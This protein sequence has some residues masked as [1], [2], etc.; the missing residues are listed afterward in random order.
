MSNAT[1]IV[2]AIAQVAAGGT[3]VQGVMALVRR[4]GELRQLDN[5]TDSVAV[6]TAEHVVKMVREELDKTKKELEKKE[7]D[8]A[9]ERRLFERQIAILSNEV[10][11]L[12]TDNAMMKAELARLRGSTT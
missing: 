8:G 9:R 5:Q 11:D 6:G 12:R 3:I 4:R 1:Q 2:T 10:A 7:E